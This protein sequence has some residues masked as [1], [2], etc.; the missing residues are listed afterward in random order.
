MGCCGSKEAKAAK[1]E[2]HLPPKP[3]KG[4]AKLPT[5]SNNS[6]NS[7]NAMNIT[8]RRVGTVTVNGKTTATTIPDVLYSKS[9]WQGHFDRLDQS[10]RTN[11]NAATRGARER[12]LRLGVPRD[13]EAEWEDV[14]KGRSGKA[15]PPPS[16]DTATSSEPSIRLNK[17]KAKSTVSA[18]KPVAATARAA[19]SSDTQ[20][21]IA[22]NNAL[23][24]GKGRAKSSSSDTQ[25][26]IAKNNALDKGKG[27]AKS[28]SSANAPSFS[29]ARTPAGDPPAHLRAESSASWKTIPKKRNKKISP[30]RPHATPESSG[31]RHPALVAARQP[32]T[33]TSSTSTSSAIL[34]P[35]TPPWAIWYPVRPAPPRLGSSDLSLL[36][37]SPTPPPTPPSRAPRR[38]A[39]RELKR[40]DRQLLASNS[41]PR[42][43][44]PPAPPPSRQPSLARSSQGWGTVGSPLH[45]SGSS[46][47]TVVITRGGSQVQ[48]DDPLKRRPLRNKLKKVKKSS[49]S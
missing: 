17:G 47:D 43:P 9:S 1:K 2:A 16:P 30:R 19:T 46:A 39:P 42:A 45:S 18:T 21:W 33:S 28:S 29:G 25:E 10:L 36:R 15:A 13:Y 31:T 24:K 48:T 37:A 11:P 40:A 8:R 44:T 49:S 32:I 22:K 23:D 4:V 41:P 26:W 5:A 35:P 3:A 27:R 14:P 34:P 38:V 6:T 7:A 20:E 12:I